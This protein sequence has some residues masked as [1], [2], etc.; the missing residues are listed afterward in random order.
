M[1]FPVR[2]IKKSCFSF[3]IVLACFVLTCLFPTYK[4][5]PT[6]HKRD[7]LFHVVVCVSLFVVVVDISSFR[8]S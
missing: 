5:I 3:L 7:I 8:E 4:N 6:A 2:E 1:S